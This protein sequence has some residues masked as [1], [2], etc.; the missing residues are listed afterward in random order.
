MMQEQNDDRLDPTV[1]YRTID[2][3]YM[4][5]FFLSVD[6]PW[7]VFVREARWSIRALR[8][9]GRRFLCRA[10]RCLVA[11]HLYLQI[12][13]TLAGRSIIGRHRCYEHGR[14]EKKEAHR[15]IRISPSHFRQAE[16]TSYLIEAH[17]GSH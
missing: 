15:T 16:A 11:P 2:V 4:Q 14:R 3:H 1:P 9:P 10:M 5:R 12:A 8:I 6:E 13:F 7:F 17:H